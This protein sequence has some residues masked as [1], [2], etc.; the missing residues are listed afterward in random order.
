MCSIQ[1]LITPFSSLYLLNSAASDKA[2]LKEIFIECSLDAVK[3]NDEIKIDKYLMKFYFT[4]DNGNKT[5]YVF[6]FLRC[7]T[8]L[9]KIICNFESLNQTLT[10]Y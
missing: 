8:N 6:M 9:T 1:I 10:T 2:T 5:F 4:Q 3:S 7:L